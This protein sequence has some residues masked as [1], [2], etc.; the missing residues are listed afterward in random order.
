MDIATAAHHPLFQSLVLPLLLSVLGIGLIRKL[1]GPARAAAAVGFAVVASMV[2]MTGWPVQPQSVMHKLPWVVATAWVAGVALDARLAGRFPQWLCL[3]VLWLAASWWLGSR[4]AGQ[5]AVFMLAGAAVLACLLRPPG[6]R[7]DTVTA[8]LI[9]S[10]G[11]AGLGFAAGS[12]A[13][14]QLSLLLAA[15]LGGAG[16]WLWPKPRIRFGAAAAA[17]AGVGWLAL[18]QVALLLVPLRP[19][20]LALAAAAFAT[21]P[22]LLRL[23]PRLS[24]LA[25][26][27]AV[28]VLAGALVCAALTWQA[29]GTGDSG[30]VEG[31]AGADDAYYEKR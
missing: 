3:S 9:A 7:A 14:F 4:S 25:A 27:L 10:L 20:A 17:V 30:A 23:R 8:A 13:L 12:L 31:G 26:P 29:A 28:A 16:L 15:A 1:T 5:G 19:S 2:W 22:L 11:L 24:P 21:A 18:A 6:D